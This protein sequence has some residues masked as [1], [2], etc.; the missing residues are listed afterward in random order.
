MASNP[1]ASE[2]SNP[3][4]GTARDQLLERRQRLMGVAGG[5]E[6]PEVVGLV[7]EVDAALA[8]IESGGFGRCEVC[9]D[10]IDRD[11]L[12]ADPLVRVC[13]DCMSADQRRFLEYDLQLA[14]SIQTALLPPRQATGDGWEFH[15]EYR[16]LAVVS[17]DY[18][19]LIRRDRDVL[20]ILGDVSGKGIAAAMLMANLQ[21]AFRSLAALE[22]SLD[23]VMARANRLFLAATPPSSYATLV[24]G[25]LHGDGMLEIG[26]AGHTPP[27]LGIGSE[28]LEIEATGVPLGLFA[29][30]RFGVN[31]YRLGAGDRLLLYTDGVSEAVNERGEE[32]G[33]SPLCALMC[34]S[35]GLSASEHTRAALEEVERFRGSAP[36]GDDLTLAA[37]RRTAA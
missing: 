11:R 24:C 27:L 36:V 20:F 4:A 28:V 14:A 33:L 22:L 19:D 13:L 21:A 25:R 37:L 34:R 3:V 18:C 9:H 5:R 7:E 31:T 15:L 16:P 1:S 32:Y 30:A 26:N 12:A 6:M 29:S 23:E 2:A 35:R 8:R 10:A 17:G